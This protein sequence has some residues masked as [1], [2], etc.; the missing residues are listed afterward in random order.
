ME[1]WEGPVNYISHHGV[2]KPSSV[3]KALRLVSNSSLKNAQSGGVS[4]NDFLVKGPNLLEPLL[5]VIANFRT[6][7]NV[8]TWDYTKAYNTVH[9][10]PEEMHMGR[11]VWRYDEDEPWRIFGIDRMHFGDRPAAAGL[12]VAKKKVAGFGKQIDEQTAEIITWGYM[13]D[14]LGGGLEHVVKKLMGVESFYPTE[15]ES[16]VA[17]SLSYRGKQGQDQALSY[18]GKQGEEQTLSYRGRQ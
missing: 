13:D 18:R 4:Y 3:T 7:P 5:Q 9:T 17:Q 2:P 14:G 15:E 8:L 12:E 16:N 10:Y 1:T 11:L 6:L